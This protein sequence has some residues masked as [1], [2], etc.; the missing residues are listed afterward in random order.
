MRGKT[1]LPLVQT[2]SCIMHASC[3]T[4]YVPVFTTECV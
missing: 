3:N 4:S 2:T 1:D